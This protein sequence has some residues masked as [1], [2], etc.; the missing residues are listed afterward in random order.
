[1]V[2]AR[3]VLGAFLVYICLLEVCTRGTR[4]ECAWVGR[5]QSTKGWKGGREFLDRLEKENTGR[6]NRGREFLHADLERERRR[7]EG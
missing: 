6:T 3:V 1:M 2:E 4:R 5:R 7:V